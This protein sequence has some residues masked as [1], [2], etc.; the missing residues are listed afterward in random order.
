M[1]LTNLEYFLENQCWCTKMMKCNENLFEKFF[2]GKVSF[3]LGKSQNTTLIIFEN[4]QKEFKIKFFLYKFNKNENIFCLKIRD[5]FY[6][7]NHEQINRIQTPTKKNG[8]QIYFVDLFLPSINLRYSND[9]IDFLINSVEFLLKNFKNQK[10]CISK[11]QQEIISDEQKETDSILNSYSNYIQYL[12]KLQN[13]EFDENL[14][15][16]NFDSINHLQYQEDDVIYQKFD[17]SLKNIFSNKFPNDNDL[18]ALSD[19]LN[20]I[21][22]TQQ[23]KVMSKALQ[24]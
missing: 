18:N 15:Q 20:Q 12:N 19:D 22:K 21:Y 16:L 11:Y 2:E 1:K 24:K 23:L 3:F 13:E 8:N 5:Q 7:M 10:E 17:D 9:T 6:M 4:N 14:I